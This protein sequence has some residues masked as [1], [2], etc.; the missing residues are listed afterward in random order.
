MLLTTWKQIIISKIND[1]DGDE[2]L[3]FRALHLAERNAQETWRLDM[4]ARAKRLMQL[5]QKQM[6][7]KVISDNRTV[8]EYNLHKSYYFT[9]R[10][11]D[12][13]HI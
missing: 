4:L 11:V 8:P 6:R 3:G 7:K 10:Q 13:C 2:T 9:I 5:L 12:S 1:G